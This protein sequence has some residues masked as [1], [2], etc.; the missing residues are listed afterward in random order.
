MSDNA[1]VVPT[2]LPQSM[3]NPAPSLTSSQMLRA[4]RARL[5][6]DWD[7]PDLIRSGVNLPNYKEHLA[8]LLEITEVQDPE[9]SPP[10]EW[11]LLYENLSVV[12]ISHVYFGQYQAR[13]Q[14][15]LARAGFTNAFELAIL[16]RERALGTKG[17]GPVYADQLVAEGKR[18]REEQDRN[19]KYGYTRAPFAEDP[20]TPG[21]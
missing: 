12:P 10:T 5:R 21:T 13:M 7:D 15:T 1:N 19:R 6:A 4:L 2:T 3:N 20:L 16:T 9:P 8:A 11:E 14:K 18:L 17:V